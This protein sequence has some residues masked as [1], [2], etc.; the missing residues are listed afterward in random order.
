MRRMLHAA[1]R[2]LT[3]HVLRPL[4]RSMVL[5][6]ATQCSP[7]VYRE[8]SASM[9]AAHLEDLFARHT[10]CGPP[11]AHPERLC[12]NTP[13]SEAELRLAHELWLS[14]DASAMERIRRR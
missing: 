12:G 10:R 5:F 11:P 9:S 1:R 3:L 13:L 8:V 14:Y 7:S 6:G 2:A 4:W